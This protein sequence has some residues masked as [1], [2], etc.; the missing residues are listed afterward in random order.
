MKKPTVNDL[1]EII[2]NIKKINLAKLLAKRFPS[3][4]LLREIDEKTGQNIVGVKND[5]AEL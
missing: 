2:E 1:D 5:A 3:I 4:D